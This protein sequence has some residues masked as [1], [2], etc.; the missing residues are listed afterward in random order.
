MR[1][2]KTTASTIALAIAACS[3]PVWAQSETGATRETGES[4]I[5]GGTIVVTGYRLQAQQAVDAKRDNL[6]VSDS[7][8]A[9][10]V[11]SLPDFN[12]AE[13]LQRV[14]GV[15]T[16]QDNGEERFVIIRGMNKEYNF[17]TVDGL[18]IPSTDEATGGVLLDT[19]PSSVAKQVDITKS[20]TAD[21]D[22]QAIGGRIDLKTRSAF[23]RSDMLLAANA[24]IGIYEHTDQGPIEAD[25]SVQAYGVFSRA[26]GTDSN[27]GVVL[28][29]SYWKRESYTEAPTSAGSRGYYWFTEDGVGTEEPAAFA[30]PRDPYLYLYYNNRERL[31]LFGKLEYRSS[32]DSFYAYAQGYQFDRDD[33]ERRD[34]A[35]IS[36]KDYTTI[37]EDISATGGQVVGRVEPLI[38]AAY[39]IFSD[40]SKGVNTGFTYLPADGHRIDGKFGYSE[41]ALDLD[42]QKAR[43][44]RSRNTDLSYTYELLDDGSYFYAFDNPGIFADAS[45]YN[46]FHYL[47]FEPRANDE[48]VT[49]GRIDYS[50]NLEDGAYGLGFKTGFKFRL[51]DRHRMQGRDEYRAQSGV[52]INFSDY[53]L[54]HTYMT[55][56]FSDPAIFVD[57]DGIL[58]YF[59]A[60]PADFNLRSDT[61]TE[62]DIQEDILAGYAMGVYNGE[63]V[64]I[65][66]GL[67]YEETDVATSSPNADPGLGADF[68]NSRYG[69]WLPRADI[70]Y[71]IT[72]DLRLRAAYS[73][74]VGRPNYDQLN[75]VAIVTDNGPE[76]VVSGGNPT[77]RPRKADNYDLSLEYYFPTFKGLFAVGLFHKDITDE[78]YRNQVAGTIEYQGVTRDAVFVSPQNAESAS[79]TGVEIGLILDSLGSVSPALEGFGLSA[80]YAYIDSSASITYTAG[81]E[82]FTR[83]IYGLFFQP[84]HMANVQLTYQTGPFDAKIAFNYKG[85]HMK[86]IAVEDLPG[87]D[88]LYDDRTKIDLQARYWLTDQIRLFAQAKNVTDSAAHEIVGVDQRLHHTFRYAGRSYWFGISFK[89]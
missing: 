67:R 79:L 25:P 21:M 17:T 12:L 44:Y 26:F 77:L 57:L 5:E 64:R 62:Y 89:Y 32:D 87:F 71:D 24:S 9:D 33:Y 56:M 1:I 45:A 16:D 46:N 42:V 82:N 83:E 58:D 23:D 81:G 3:A 7:V 84:K 73:K 85:M 76:V 52:S 29:A 15:N 60:S 10:D 19:I 31:G 6:Q 2:G 54:D 39:D 38:E 13:A 74:S 18:V 69:T 43:F 37:P 53:V 88:R 65:T 30:V 22:G 55:P 27:F 41:A 75:P 34:I 70:A 50:Y 36:N 28:A 61:L 14:P 72:Q 78:I 48:S 11:A 66:A 20:F 63:N 8:T 80:N 49:E 35:R 47:S 4:E 86:G 40:S 51:T 59:E 68:Y